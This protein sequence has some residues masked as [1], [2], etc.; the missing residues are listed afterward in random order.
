MLDGL[1]NNRKEW[2]AKKEEYEAKLKAIE[3]AKAA[4]QASAASKGAR[5][6]LLFIH[7][8]SHKYKIQ[9]VYILGFGL[10]T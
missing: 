9:V 4:K 2:N 6:I 8:F 3:D 5:L 1:L 10:I 7:L